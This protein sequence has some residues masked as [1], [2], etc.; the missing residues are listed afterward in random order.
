ME[1][2]DRLADTRPVAVTLGAFQAARRRHAG[3]YQAASRAL[4]PLFQSRGYLFSAS[5]DW[6]F[7]PISLLPIVRGLAAM[8]LTGALRLGPWPTDLRP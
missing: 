1:L 7:T 8:M 6:I 3:L 4:T 2:A 5:R